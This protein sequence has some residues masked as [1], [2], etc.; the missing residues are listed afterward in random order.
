MKQRNDDDSGVGNT[1]STYC[2][3]ILNHHLAWR[4]LADQSVTTPSSAAFEL[5]VHTREKGQN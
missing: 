1:K 3:G 5:F 2:H 4:D